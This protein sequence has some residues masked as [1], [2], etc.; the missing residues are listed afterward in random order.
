MNKNSLYRD[1][2][3]FGSQYPLNLRMKDCTKFID[4]TEDNFE[5]VRYNPRKDIERYGLSITSLDG[6]LSGRPD[7]DSLPQYNREHN[8]TWTERDFKVPTPVYEGWPSLQECLAPFKD[9]IFRTHILKLNSG[10]YFPPHKDHPDPADFYK[11]KKV[12]F[13]T[14]RLIMPMKNCAPPGMSFIL[15]DKILNWEQGYLYFIDTA[16]THYLFNTTETPAYWLV[17]NVDVNEQTLADVC[18]YM[19]RG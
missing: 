7:L 10:G 1:L 19:K 18:E 13:D 16:R 3:T 14:F 9:Y 4:W 17:V 11:S 2:T 8:T 15:E 6:G 12:V 5:Y